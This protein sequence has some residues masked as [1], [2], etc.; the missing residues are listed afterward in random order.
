[1]YATFGIHQSSIAQARGAAQAPVSNY[2]QKLS[3]TRALVA[4]KA[5]AAAAA[6]SASSS[7]PQ[8]KKRNCCEE[9]RELRQAPPWLLL[10]RT[11]YA[12]SL[13]DAAL[14]LCAHFRHLQQRLPKGPGPRMHA[15]LLP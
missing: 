10:A 4:Q 15:R 6:P 11:G 8:V 14:S 5:A 2:A 7:R 3:A 9:L 12:S 13:D 1:M